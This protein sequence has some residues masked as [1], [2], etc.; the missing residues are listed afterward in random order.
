MSIRARCNYARQWRQWRQQLDAAYRA[1]AYTAGDLSIRIG[2]RHP[3]LDTLL[4]T[5]AYREW[6]YLTAANPRSRCL[7]DAE[8]AARM[9]VLLGLLAAQPVQLLLGQSEAEAPDVHGAWPPEPGVLVLGCSLVLAKRLGR[10][11]AQHAVVH[12]QLK[13]PARLIWLVF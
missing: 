6:A 9:A 10:L 2:A 5:H 4:A 3:L 7:S 11:F 12:G 8:N 13:A 1:T